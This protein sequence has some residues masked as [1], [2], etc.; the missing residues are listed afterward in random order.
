MARLDG[1][2]VL[3][4]CNQIANDIVQLSTKF[5]ARPAGS[6]AGEVLAGLFDVQGLVVLVTGGASGLGPLPGVPP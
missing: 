2:R 1:H 3:P 4:V 5:G 6:R